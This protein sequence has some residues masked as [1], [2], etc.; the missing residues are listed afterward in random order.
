MGKAAL[1]AMRGHG[2]GRCQNHK[3]RWAVVKLQQQALCLPCFEKQMAGIGKIMRGLR[4]AFG[5]GVRG[6][7]A[8]AIKHE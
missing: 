1:Y 8:L 2:F 3:R 6:E 7:V 5:A 4:D